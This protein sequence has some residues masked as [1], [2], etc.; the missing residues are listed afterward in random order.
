MVTRSEASGTIGLLGDLFRQISTLLNVEVDLLRVELT[1][2]SSRAAASLVKVA[3][4]AALFIAGILALSAAF[5]A[6]LVRLGLPIDLACLLVAAIAMLAGWMCLRSGLRS[7][8]PGVLIPRRTLN[9]ITSLIT[10][11]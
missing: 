4:G 1:E 3:A 7:L 5:C 10:G 2:S 9:Q 11:A 8:E 6:F